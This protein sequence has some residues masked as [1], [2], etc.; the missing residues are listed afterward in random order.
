[1]IPRAPFVQGVEVFWFVPGQKRNVIGFSKRTIE[2]HLL[3]FKPNTPFFLEPSGIPT[4]FSLLQL[5]DVRA[6]EDIDIQFGV[7]TS[8]GFF[9]TANHPADGETPI[10]D[11]LEM[12][13]KGFF[14]NVQP[15]SS[16]FSSQTCTTFRKHVP[17][18]A[19][20]FYQ[21]SSTEKPVYRLFTK[22]CSPDSS[23]TTSFFDTCPL[24]LT[25]ELRAP[26]LHYEVDIPTM[27]FQELRNPMFFGQLLGRTGLHY[28][29]RS[30]EREH[31]PGKK[32][33]IRMNNGKSALQFTNMAYSSWTSMTMSIR[34][35]TMPIKETIMSFQFHESIVNIVAKPDNGNQ[36]MIYLEHNI[37]TKKKQSI[38]QQTE[39]HMSLQVWYL[40]IIQQY[41]HGF[42]FSL[43]PISSPPSSKSSTSPIT[44]HHST[45][46]T[47]SSD[48]MWNIIVGG[49]QQTP[50]MY[51][52]VSF[53]YD[54]AW[55]HF[56]DYPLSSEE[57]QRDARAD[58]IYTAFPTTP[59]SYQIRLPS[60]LSSLS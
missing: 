48:S 55:V 12:D 14:G 27:E 57:I 2:T 15:T 43:Q 25:C 1:L 59:Y 37:G 22:S 54:I 24:S 19:K 9:I 58:W 29:T 5:T 49:G 7:E 23:S 39:Y 40:M 60:S 18:I 36:A 20:L 47:T 38:I 56:F 33:F 45:P 10:M 21:H 30:E 50:T 16:S 17:N 31:V 46:L 8:G 44:I 13:Q 26:F 42:H 34:L 4:T 51:S 53:Y 6:K 3:Q 52:T 28:H 35:R 41:E 32:G 11:Q